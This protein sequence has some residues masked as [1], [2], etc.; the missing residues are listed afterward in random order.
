MEIDDSP[1]AYET[2]VD[3]GTLYIFKTDF[4][5]LYEVSFKP[6]PYLFSSDK[7]YSDDTYEFS[8]IVIENPNHASPPFDN[9]IGSTI[10][11]IFDS[12]YEEFG[13]TV[14]LYICASHD[15]RQMVR[16]RK[17]NGW[18]SSFGTSKYVKL[19]AVPTDKNGNK[20]PLALVI[21]LENPYLGDIVTAFQ[22]VVSHFQNDK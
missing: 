8:I 22:E 10:A 4:E 15:N 21:R 1:Y 11:K 14:S 17:F 19:E 9:R 6:T 16:F 18:F 5:L 3:A 13:N 20:F 7:P 12:F 2:I